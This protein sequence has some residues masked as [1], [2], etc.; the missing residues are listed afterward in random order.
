MRSSLLCHRKHKW[1]RSTS[2]KKLWKHNQATRFQLA[3]LKRLSM[4]WNTVFSQKKKK[5]D[6]FYIS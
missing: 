6:T 4:L 5:S 2:R 3:V 1:N